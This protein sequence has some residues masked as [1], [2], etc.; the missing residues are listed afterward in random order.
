MNAFTFGQFQLFCDT[1]TEEFWFLV[2]KLLNP[3]L[4][5]FFAS[6]LTTTSNALLF[7]ATV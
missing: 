1:R 5:A 6:R 2:D 4:A 3:L 7:F